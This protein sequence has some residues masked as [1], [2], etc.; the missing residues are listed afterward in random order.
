VADGKDYHDKSME[1]LQM[2]EYVANL[3]FQSRILD[4]VIKDL[5]RA[6]HNAIWSK[7]MKSEL[8]STADEIEAY[9]SLEAYLARGR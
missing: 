8:L 3:R 2:L 5:D 6:G 4:A 9:G 7:Q 1:E